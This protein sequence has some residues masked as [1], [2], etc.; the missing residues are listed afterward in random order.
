MY[1][2]DIA[3]IIIVALYAFRGY[4][5]GFILSIVGILSLL[6]SLAAAYY[7]GTPA[8]VLLESFQVH[9]TIETFLNTEVFVNN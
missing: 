8:R 4:Q 2:L 5:R 1:I 6:G 3:I 7:L 9:T